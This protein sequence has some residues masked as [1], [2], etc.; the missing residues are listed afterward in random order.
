MKNIVTWK[1]QTV[2]QT[3]QNNRYQPIPPKA[4]S[5]IAGFMA[6]KE[7]SVYVCVCLCVCIIYMVM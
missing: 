3:T 2:K 6:L 4:T 1:K 7:A 5:E